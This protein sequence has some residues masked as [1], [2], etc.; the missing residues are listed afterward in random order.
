MIIILTTPMFAKP[1]IVLVLLAL[2]QTKLTVTLAQLT[3][4]ISIITPVH[5]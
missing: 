4:R 1:A 5:A 3:A 2:G